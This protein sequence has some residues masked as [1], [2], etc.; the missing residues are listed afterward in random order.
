MH[1][2]RVKLF[3]V[4]F[5]SAQPIVTIQF[6]IPSI[7]QA[8][9]LEW[10]CCALLRDL[11]S[12]WTEATS[13]LSPALASAV[14]YQLPPSWK[15]NENHTLSKTCCHLSVGNK[16]KDG[17]GFVDRYF[18]GFYPRGCPILINFFFNVILKLKVFLLFIP[19]LNSSDSEL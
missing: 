10:V 1:A 14:L 5:N 3:P 15:S 6:L 18:N 8:R 19:N 7:L 4:V 11:P 2:S 17:R 16:I 13:L 12:P 9:I